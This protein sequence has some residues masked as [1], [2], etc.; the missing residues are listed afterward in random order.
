M[1]SHLG[2]AGRAQPVILLIELCCHE[3]WGA[4]FLVESSVAWSIAQHNVILLHS[5]S[6]KEK[7]L[8]NVI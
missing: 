1:A 7:S 3:I 4:A 8:E 2:D 6:D 5:K